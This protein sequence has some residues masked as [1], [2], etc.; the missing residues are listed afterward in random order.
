MTAYTVYFSGPRAKAL[1]LAP[2]DVPL[3][4]LFGGPHISQPSFLRAGVQPG[5]RL[6]IVTVTKGTLYVLGA[7]TVATLAQTDDLHP[8]EFHAHVDTTATD[9]WQARSGWSRPAFFGALLTTCVSEALTLTD[10]I[11][12]F[13][14][15]PLPAADLNTL[16]Y[17][18]RRGTRK[19][20]G[21]VDGKITK[22]LAFQGIYR[23]TPDSADRLDSVIR[24]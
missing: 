7:A 19:P 22:P 6:F 5:D 23:L 17:E 9:R 15:R 16:T 2:A 18:N 20:Q 21:I 8:V 11:G 14:P 3:P 10:A 4:C 13:A 1:R 12:P 24:A